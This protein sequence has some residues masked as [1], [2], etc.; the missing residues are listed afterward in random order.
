VPV[1]S[2]VAAHPDLSTFAAVLEFV[3]AE[4]TLAAATDADLIVYAPTNQAFDAFA[5]E[6]TGRANATGKDLLQPQY[7]PLLAHVA[8]SHVTDDDDDDGVY[9]SIG[10]QALLL[11][12]GD[13]QDH[14]NATAAAVE[15]LPS[16]KVRARLLREEDLGSAGDL[17]V[18]DRVLRPDDVYA[19]PSAALKADPELAAFGRLLEALAPKIVQSGDKGAPATVFVPTKAALGKFLASAGLTEAKVLAASPAVK[20]QVTGT[21]AY[22]VV[23]GV[24]LNVDSLRGDDWTLQTALVVGAP[25]PPGSKVPTAADAVR[26]LRVAKVSRDGAPIVVQGDLSKAKVTASSQVY[27]GAMVIQKVDNVLVP[28]VGGAAAAAAKPAQATPTTTTTTTAAAGGRKLLRTAMRNNIAANTQRANI[29]RA[30]SGSISVQQATALNNRVAA[31]APVGRVPAYFL[32]SGA[33]APGGI[34][35]G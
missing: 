8:S 21:L 27:A 11:V 29:R 18:V 33:Q 14:K 15:V 28:A 5:K 32:T 17:Y 25:P 26:T 35:M 9:K 24:G 22:H 4:Q 10:G 30:M 7:L 23:P 6:M 2:A 12:D 13:D 34:W 20:A 16:K 1:T 31:L 19:T 3:G